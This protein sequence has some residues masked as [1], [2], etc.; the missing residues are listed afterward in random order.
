VSSQLGSLSS[1]VA[2]ASAQVREQTARAT[3][4][5]ESEHARL[6]SQFESLPAVS[7]ESTEAMR[8]ALHDQVRALEQ[9]SSLTARG[10]ARRDVAPPADATAPGSGPVPLPAP[11]GREDRGRALTSLT[12][13]LSNDLAARARA[14]AGA[15]PAEGREGWKLGE[16]LARASREEDQQGQPALPAPPPAQASAPVMTSAPVLDVN[17]IA[18]ALDPATA[19]A[20]W[21]R[22]RAGQ[23][24]IMVRSIYTAEGRIA[25]DEVSRR[26]RSEPEFQASIHRYIADFERILQETEQRDQTGRMVQHQLVSDSGRV[27]LFFAHV[28]GRL[29]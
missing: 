19:S 1:N 21:S 23:R 26:Y 24:G 5:I 16:L 11:A 27:Y 4:E 10:A 12:A 13:T 20:I 29:S 14:N 18:R 28:S 8:R 17:I 9:L 15:P 3:A 6:R 7:R 25:F 2:Q 22:F